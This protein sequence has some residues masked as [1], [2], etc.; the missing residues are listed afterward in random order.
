MLAMSRPHCLSVSSWLVS[1]HLGLGA[2]EGK[3]LVSSSTQLFIYWG[4]VMG[5]S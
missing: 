1:G 4:P 5:W 3:G 2:E